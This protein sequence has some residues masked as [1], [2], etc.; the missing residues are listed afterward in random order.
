MGEAAPEARILLVLRRGHA[1]VVGHG[2]HQAADHAGEGQGH[3]RSRR[4]RSCRRASWRRRPARRH[5]GAD[6][7]FQ[8]D[9]LVHR[10][11]GIEVGIARQRLRASRSPACRDRRRRRARRIPRRRGRRLRC[12]KAEA[13]WRRG[14]AIWGIAAAMVLFR[15]KGKNRPASGASPARRPST[16]VN[17]RIIR[18]CGACVHRGGSLRAARKAAHSGDK[19]GDGAA[20]NSMHGRTSQPIIRQK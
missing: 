18:I 16:N 9:L 8:R 15:D 14:V 4:R 1:D 19:H 17:W 7:D 6:G 10:P 11:F 3:Q 2:D 20:K 5:R 12:R 13:G